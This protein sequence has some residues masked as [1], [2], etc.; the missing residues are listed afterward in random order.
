[1]EKLGYV[2]RRE[3]GTYSLHHREYARLLLLAADGDET[4]LYRE[5][6]DVR[7]FVKSVWR[8][9]LEDRP[10]L[11]GL[12]AHQARFDHG[13]LSLCLCLCGFDLEGGEAYLRFW[14]EGSPCCLPAELAAALLGRLTRE[15]REAFLGELAKHVGAWNAAFLLDRLEGEDREAFLRSLLENSCSR[16]LSRNSSFI[17]RPKPIT[18]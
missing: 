15:D 14:E 10:E 3:G 17:S 13:A 9:A 16:I 12:L 7:E 6:G 2:V 5:R 4:F 18:Q 11:G 1:M 8:R